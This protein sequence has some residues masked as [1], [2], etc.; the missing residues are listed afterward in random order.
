MILKSKLNEFLKVIKI[1]K[2][3]SLG[4]SKEYIAE[5]LPINPVIVEAGAH[6][7]I[8]TIEMSE[9]WKN[10]QIHAFEPVPELYSKLIE[11]TRYLKNIKHYQYAL[12]E[13][14]GSAE[15][16]I[17]HG[18]SDGSSSLMKP[19]EHLKVHPNVYF[20]KKITVQTVNLDDWAENL[21]IRK[22]DFLWLDLQG[23]ELK[24]L[25]SAPKILYT[26]NAIY[27][28]V[29]LKEMYENASLYDEVKS[30]LY[31]NG[32]VVEKEDL[33]WSDMGNVFFVRNT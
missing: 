30:W 9:I 19:K 18:N 27:T 4:I 25:K 7:G 28:E 29:S 31:S 11:N 3:S 22:V 15:I 13:L 14:S 21:E 32:F 1:R 5:Y 23:Y 2:N 12:A 6:I 24:V 20:E 26:V 33:R 10:G 8:D 16:N 17:S